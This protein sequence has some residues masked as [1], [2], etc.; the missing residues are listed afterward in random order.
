MFSQFSF[1]S[2]MDFFHGIND[3]VQKSLTVPK[4]NWYLL[5]PC[6]QGMWNT[7]ISPFIYKYQFWCWFKMSFYLFCLLLNNLPVINKLKYSRFVL[8]SCSYCCL[9][10][11]ALA[12]CKQALWAVEFSSFWLNSSTDEGRSFFSFSSSSLYLFR[13]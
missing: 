8:S 9:S 13:E 6:C 5:V 10:F 4:C 11:S 3:L 2:W 1:Y 12:V 7:L